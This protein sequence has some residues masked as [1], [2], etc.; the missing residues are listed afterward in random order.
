MPV[1]LRD[2]AKQLNLS[3]ATV[4]FVLNE[5]K[6]VAIPEA[7]RQRVFKVARE[8]GYRPNMAARAL[9]SGRTQILSVCVPQIRSPHYSYVFHTLVEACQAIGYQVLVSPS[10]PGMFRRAMDWPVDGVFVMDTPEVIA[11]GDIPSHIPI[12]SVGTEVNTS[13]DHVWVDIA[14]GAA[15]AMRHL[16]STGRRRIAFIGTP[17]APDRMSSFGAAYDRAMSALGAEPWRIEVAGGDYEAARLAARRAGESANRPDGF[18][19]Q[20]D[21]IAIAAIRGMADLGLRCPDDFAVVGGDGTDIGGVTIPTLTTVASPV[22]AMCQAA[23]EM[24]INRIK[25]DKL[26]LQ[27]VSLQ[28]TLM[29]RESTLTEAATAV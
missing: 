27:S 5:R 6:D 13:L 8:L 21:G 19:C 28:G 17:G 3:H 9:V 15:E 20:D 12:V 29:V 4:S 7:T 11:S 22:P 18:F 1:T 2:I 10:R 14:A 26:P 24:L 23:L 25:D 16:T